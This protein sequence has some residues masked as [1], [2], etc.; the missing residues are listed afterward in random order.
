MWLF[1]FFN[2]LF[3]THFHFLSIFWGVTLT[4]TIEGKTIKLFLSKEKLLNFNYQRKK[5]QQTGLWVSSQFCMVI[6]QT[7]LFRQASSRSSHGVQPAAG[8]F[9]L[10]WRNKLINY[11]LINNLRSSVSLNILQNISPRIFRNRLIL[12]HHFSDV[13]CP[14]ITMIQLDSARGKPASDVRVYSDVLRGLL[15][16]SAKVI[17]K[18]LINWTFCYFKSIKNCN[19][20]I[21]IITC[22]FELLMALLFNSF[23]LDILIVYWII[24]ISIYYFGTF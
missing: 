23:P 16:S 1:W 21:V 13:L 11:W 9:V 14:F 20:F 18:V 24:L 15:A 2:V 5:D 17:R 3:F 12:L 4:L 22:Y 10:K 6:Q 19:I 7:K 8:W